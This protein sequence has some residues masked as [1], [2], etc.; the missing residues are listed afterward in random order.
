MIAKPGNVG[1]PKVTASPYLYFGGRCDEAI[2]FY[3]QAVG[4]EV[5]FV[6]RYKDGPDQSMTPPAA[7]DKVMH[8]RILVGNTV[9]FVSDGHCEGKTD[10]KGFSLSI[11]APSEADAERIFEALAKGGSVTM[12]M[13]KTFFSP[14]FGMVVDKFG[15]P[16]MV[17]KEEPA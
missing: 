9:I 6:F 1:N 8:A 13:G 17:I 3:E 4:A 5:Q 10:F 11:A 12:P 15:V 14:K 7:G 16:W 2:E